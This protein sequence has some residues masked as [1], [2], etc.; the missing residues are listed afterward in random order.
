M[1]TS[2][3][4]I[5]ASLSAVMLLASISATYV[6]V[7]GPVNATL[8]G[9]QTSF[10]LGKVGPGESFYVLASANTTNAK[11]ELVN[12][13]WDQLEAIGLPA[14][15]TSQ[16]SSLYDNPMKMKIT[17]SPNAYGNYT[18]KLRA[19]NLKNYSGLGNFTFTGYVNVT[20]DVLDV[21]VSPAN[22][23]S[24]IGQPANL[25]VSIGNTGISDDPFLISATGLP[26][27]NSTDTVISV[28]GTTGRYTYPVF[29]DEPGVYSFNL[30]VSSTT[31]ALV[32]KSF[33]VTFTVKESLI[34]DYD[35][36]GNG[37]SLS[38]IIF[39]PVYAFMS[40][41]DYVYKLAL[42]QATI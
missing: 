42:H 15:W 4:F 9:S 8:N 1:R 41:L 25:Y 26:A 37:V 12:V 17:V 36:V 29:A 21:A 22:L 10:Y 30:T 27:W 24:G 38:P 34:N 16:S 3:F 35:A 5:L 31:S 13:G 2:G 28:H 14:G 32:K 7:E 11:G 33:P 23:R 40:L 6:V 19:V 20:P 39:E 18:L